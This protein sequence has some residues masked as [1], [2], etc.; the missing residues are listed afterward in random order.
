[1]QVNPIGAT[2]TGASLIAT[3]GFYAQD[4]A[5]SDSSGMSLANLSGLAAIDSYVAPALNNAGTFMANA[6]A[7]S[8]RLLSLNGSLGSLL[9][10]AP[11][12]EIDNSLGSLVLNNDW[13]LSSAR[14]GPNNNVPGFLTLR[15]AQN[16]Y[17]QASLSDGFVSSY[18]NAALKTQNSRQPANF[19][20]WAYQIT[21]GADES[22][23]NTQAVT[24]AVK[25]SVIL[26]IPYQNGAQAQA[27][28]PG[29]SALTS[30]A[31]SGTGINYYQVIR[32][33]SGNIAINASGDLQLWNQF[34]SIYTV[35][36]KVT[37]PT[38]GGTFSTPSPSNY[39]QDSTQLN[40]GA[41]QQAVA[42]APQFSYAGGNISVNVNGNIG[43]WSLDANATPGS[44][45]AD[46]VREL[47]SNWLYRRGAVDS[48]GLFSVI[49][50]RPD[51]SHG[52][53]S[54]VASTAWWV[55]F[56]NFFD[57]FGT[58]GGGNINLEAGGSISNVNASIPT[59]FRMAGKDSG[60]NVL[61]ASQATG[62]ELGGG[63]LQ[64]VAG[65]NIDAGV[66]YV[67]RG[68]ALLQA[69]GSII[70]NPTRDPAAPVLTAPTFN[71]SPLSYLPTTFFLGKGSIDVMARGDVLLGPVANVF[72]TPQ[73]INNGFWL[74]DY[75][76]TYDP[77]DKVSVLSLGGNMTLRQSAA[78]QAS[79]APLPLLQSWINNFVD[80]SDMS[81]AS[82]YQPWLSVVE[83]D[84]SSDLIPTSVLPVGLAPLFSLMPST[85]TAVSLSGDINLQGNLT[86]MPSPNGTL[87]LVVDGNINGLVQSGTY[88]QSATQVQK[89]YTA[90][91][92]NVSD[93]N[94]DLIPGINSPLSKRS[95]LPSSKVND[96][97]SNGT[98]LSYTTDVSLA[99][100][101]SGSINGQ[102]ATAAL[103]TLLHGSNLLHAGDT[104]QSEIYA[105]NGSIS[106]LQLFSPKATSVTAGQ[107]I[108][109]I[110]FYIQNDTANSIS[111]V[112]AGRNIIA[113]DPSSPLQQNAQAALS[114][115]LQSGDI[116]VSGPGTLEVLAGG[117]VDLGVNP[118]NSGDSSVNIG[119]TSI[120]NQRNPSLPFNGADLVVSSGVK[121]PTGLSS[122]G[123]LSLDSFAQTI[124]QSPDASSYLSEL[125]TQMKPSDQYTYTGDPLLSEH[126]TAADFGDDSTLTPEQKSRLELQ[127]FYIV[128]ANSYNK[129]KSFATTE[130]AI[131]QVVNGKAGAGDIIT[132]SQDIATING[133]NINLFAPGGSITMGNLNY[134]KGGGSVAPGIIT[135][136]GG[137]INIF[138]KQDVSIGIGRI[139]SLKGGDI[140]IL[141]DLGNIAAGNSSKTVQSA[142]PTQVLL[143]LQ[144]ALVQT[145]LAGLATGGGIGTLQTIL[146]API[147]NIVLYAIQGYIDAGDAG[148][149]ASGNISVGAGAGVRNADNFQAGGLSIGVP[150]AS[151]SSASSSAP[152][153]A[154]AVASA[155]SSAASTA[156]AAAA[157]SSADKTADKGN[158]NQQDSTP[159]EYTITIDGY[160]G[161]DGDDDDK[162]AAN[163]AVA[164][165]QASL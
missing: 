131:K 156:A 91:T 73:G 6:T 142:P 33:G 86:F 160:G 25:G 133:G 127:L 159:S 68:N 110:G 134:R 8:T 119:I 74:S 54:Q 101:E 112:S 9:K 21:A 163:A 37:D 107:D 87:S 15:A 103:K 122:D 161:G 11:G 28:S 83:T 75:F 55:D 147:A 137:V 34:A 115:S 118:G 162:K 125:S 145:D 31:L 100:F 104:A 108:T 14:F 10:V 65:G 18:F 88:T 63:N 45:V 29:P 153:S 49:T 79:Q 80:P 146:S 51:K 130:T 96:V 109:D 158:S 81:H 67:E 144:S 102:Y 117:N 136:G 56:S 84:I 94:P 52:P 24:S 22:A 20:S 13:D 141:S 32:T 140:T 27:P 38:L 165:I 60:G 77:N 70:T 48:G 3:E 139:F 2:I 154:P 85:L 111:I 135:E 12:E 62:V 1:V 116:Q 66:F 44:M 43:Q 23:V 64:V 26:G 57:D 82:Y 126:H 164:P 58:L 50:L 132:W 71:N 36:T 150:A 105:G 149:R 17:F 151:S 47:P 72:M 76:S 78:T 143:D 90:S 99:F 92:I 157:N 97:F 121:L 106:G 113:Y 69:A 128:L 4:A 42:Y 59:N 5:Q 39:K 129:T 35:G 152:A 95:S 16:I 19:Q 53:V 93:A 61:L 138:T 7:I 40:F 155:P 30:D 89:I 46:S 124:L 123:V 114:G 98:K 41:I 120:G 148:I